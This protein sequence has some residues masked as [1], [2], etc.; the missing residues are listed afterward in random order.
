MSARQTIAATA[1]FLLLALFS[2]LARDVAAAEERWP[3]WQ[4]YTEAED[5]ARQKALQRKKTAAPNLAL[6]NRRI[7]QLKAAGKYAQAVLLA[8]Q[9]L[10]LAEKKGADSIEVA[11]ALDTL[12]DL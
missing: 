4:S 7:A 9:A 10:A 8:Q 12:A 6:L 3:P 1:L 5:T 11:A 2:A